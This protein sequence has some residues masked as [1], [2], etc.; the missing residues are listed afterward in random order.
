[1]LVNYIIA[2][3]LNIIKVIRKSQANCLKII[4][5]VPVAKDV[6][7]RIL[8]GRQLVLISLIV[9]VGLTVGTAGVPEVKCKVSGAS[10]RACLPTFV[11]PLSDNNVL[12]E[13]KYI[14][15]ML[16]AYFIEGEQIS[17]A[18]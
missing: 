18:L 14:L 4:L 2:C 13:I 3:T 16:T 7:G 1:M 8:N 15:N 5:G 6:V 17:T 9:F 11:Q 10:A 12:S